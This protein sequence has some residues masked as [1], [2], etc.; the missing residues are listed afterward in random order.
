MS[1][2][3]KHYAGLNITASDNNGKMR[4]VSRI[5]LYVDDENVVT[6][7][8]DTGL[9]IVAD[10]PN[11][12][13]AIAD[14]LLAQF[15]GFVYQAMSAEDTEIDPAAELGDGIT[16]DGMYSVIAK[17][18]DDG[19]GFLSVSAPGE[20]E[21]EDE[22][23]MD[24][25]LTKALTHAFNR[26]IAETQS[27]ITKTS[28]EIRLE[29]KNTK[30]GLENTIRQTASSL[31]SE[32]SSSEAR[33]KSLVEQTA[34]SLR[35]EISSSEGRSKSLVEQTASSLKSE[36]SSSEERSKS[37][38]EQSVGSIKLSVSGG[39]GGSASI[40]LSGGGEGGGTIDLS[41]V[42]SAFAN[43]NSEV[44]ISGG[45]VTFN[46]GTFVVNST[47][48]GVTADGTI[49]AN[50][51][52]IA[53]WSITPGK[54][55]AGNASTGVAVVQTPQDSTGYVFAA[56][57]NSHD[58][59]A[60]C[61]FRVQKD[62]TLY[63]T[64]ANITGAVNATSGSFTGKIEA[65]SGNIGDWQIN[66][67]G[68]IYETADGLQR[69]T[70]RG[71]GS[72]ASGTGVFYIGTRTSASGSFTY[73]FRV[74][75]DGTC[76]ATKFEMVGGTMS[77]TNTNSGTISGG[78]FS[79]G[80]VSGGTLTGST[81]GTFSGGTLSGCN[82]GGTSLS[83]GGGGG[84]LSSGSSGGVISG[85]LRVATNNTSYTSTG[86]AFNNPV[87]VY[88]SLN[89][90]GD[91]DRMMS[92]KHYGKRLLAAYETPL[93]TFSDYGVARL[94][95][96]GVFYIVIDPVF[97]E[98]V[99]NAYLPTAFLTKYGEGDIWVEEVAHDIIT[100]RGTPGMKFAWET[101]YAQGNARVERLR[102][103]GFDYMDMSNEREFDTDAAV[104]YEHSKENIDYAEMGFEYFREF[105]RSIEAA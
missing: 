91:K 35:T 46:S 54:L 101:R 3:D 27:S 11:A 42:R 77:G 6:A 59:Y 70:M 67:N 43:D 33:S 76:R 47:N 98:M 92:T 74:D 104:A 89:V 105:E 96:T 7:G 18:A 97:A 95:D 37:L 58:S 1:S 38:I 17:I 66:S 102:V 24:G 20:E 14:M 40:T 2:F 29:V 85:Y 9:E 68:I 48:F 21:L 79:N 62:G 26:K 88:S 61:P 28:E 39:L 25:P 86:T 30:E 5:T 93:A 84:S 23:P 32:I 72:G 53:G 63:A 51:G 65:S 103:M 81:G 57:G 44:A 12:T 82:L 22:Y 60:N 8:D 83:F 73:P 99:N 41:Q 15:K 19:T 13:Q 55:F 87:N 75:I 56:G 69:V 71:L 94:D 80:T 50:A 100:V 52:S 34:T 45:R 31:T 36:I 64:K 78:T 90:T 10:C 49:T 16:A 4:P